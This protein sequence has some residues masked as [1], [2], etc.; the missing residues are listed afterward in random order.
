MRLLIDGT[1]NA[2]VEAIKPHY[3]DFFFLLCST[4]EFLIKNYITHDSTEKSLPIS[5]MR[6]AN[7][8]RPLP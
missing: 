6:Q 2:F 5:E 3:Y 4:A 7:Q 8:M 1:V